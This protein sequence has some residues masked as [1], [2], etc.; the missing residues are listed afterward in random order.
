[1]K[2]ITW[3]YEFVASQIFILCEC[4]LLDFAFALFICHFFSEKLFL[5]A[6]F[7]C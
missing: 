2:V 3:G 6:L 5:I 1:M 7:H 4:M